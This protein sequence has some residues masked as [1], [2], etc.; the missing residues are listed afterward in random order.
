MTWYQPGSASVLSTL[1]NVSLNPLTENTRRRPPEPVYVHVNVY[2]HVH[3]HVH[4]NVHGHLHLHVHVRV[5]VHV[6]VHGHVHVY[7]H[8]H[9]HVHG[10]VHAYV[11]YLDGPGVRVDGGVVVGVLLLG[12]VHLQQLK[13]RSDCPQHVA[14]HDQLLTS[15]YILQQ[16]HS[17]RDRVM[18]QAGSV[19]GCTTT[20][21]Q[22]TE[23]D[24]TQI[25][26][27]SLC[28]IACSTESLHSLHLSLI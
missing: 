9:W 16:G 10:H 11:P 17:E 22:L 14:A 8:V 12:P 24:C 2:V 5:H 23:E 7:G 28:S 26:Q 18:G 4:M 25:T 13:D 3:V 19:Q 20:V 1:L 15:Q 6:H 27:L 21:T